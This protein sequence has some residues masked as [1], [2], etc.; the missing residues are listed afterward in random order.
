MTLDGWILRGYRDAGPGEVRALH[1]FCWPASWRSSPSS[2][3]CWAA[4]WPC[5]AVR[6]PTRA[7]WT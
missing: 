3:A 6:S 1:G 5:A 2:V 4:R 7:N